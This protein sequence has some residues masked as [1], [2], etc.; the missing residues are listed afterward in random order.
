MVARRA[1]NKSAMLEP[2]EYADLIKVLNASLR[3]ET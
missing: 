2:N 3:L 1:I